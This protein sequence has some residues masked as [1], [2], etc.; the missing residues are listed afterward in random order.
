M[1]QPIELRACPFCGG[2]VAFDDDPHDCAKRNCGFC[3]ECDPCYC[4]MWAF[5]SESPESLAS[6]WNSRPEAPYG[7]DTSPEPQEASDD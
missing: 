3:I 5:A 2:K 1:S 6:R 7:L 4:S